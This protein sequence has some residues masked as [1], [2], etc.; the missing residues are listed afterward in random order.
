M[1]WRKYGTPLKSGNPRGK[2]VPHPTARRPVQQSCKDCGAVFTESVSQAAK[3][4][5]CRP[6]RADSHVTKVCPECK[7][8]FT[9]GR[10]KASKYRYCSLVCRRTAAE[11]ARNKWNCVTC[12]NSVSRNP[13][14]IAGRFCSY[15]CIPSVKMITKPCANR[16]CTNSFTVES[17]NH[18]RFCCISCGVRQRIS[19]DPN[20]FGY[21]A[22]KMRTGHR[23]DIEQL[24]EQVLLRH[25]VPYEFE[26]KVGRYFIDF[27]LP[28]Q[29]DLECDGWRHAK[30]T[31]KDAIRDA[32]LREQGWKVL[33]IQAAALYGDAKKHY[34]RCWH[35]SSQLPD[36]LPVSQ[37]VACFSQCGGKS[38]RYRL[39]TKPSES[40]FTLASHEPEEDP[41]PTPRFR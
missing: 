18:K 39:P 28:G 29:V 30:T 34:R 41:S 40:P 13:S 15:A 22:W 37:G 8:L 31:E 14:Q 7:E 11:R 33:R 12:G 35:L 36:V 21:I 1:H 25:K 27:A 23:T 17:W 4:R 16:E 19:D 5:R 38:R 9:I 20:G 26:K 2:R 32:Y 10:S 6:C 24:A 3:L